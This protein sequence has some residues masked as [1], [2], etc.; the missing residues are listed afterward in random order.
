MSKIKRTAEEWK[1]LLTEEQYR[2]TRESGTEAPFSGEYEQLLDE[3]R[4]LCVCCGHALFGAESKFIA[5]CGW[6]SF[7]S[8]LN[9]AKQ[10]STINAERVNLRRFRMPS[11]GFSR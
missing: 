2:V 6:P 3:G 11:M 5:G 1:A 8:E 9:E 10:E 4:Y 7:H